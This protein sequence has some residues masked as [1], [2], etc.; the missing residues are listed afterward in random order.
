MDEFIIEGGQRL[1]GEVTLSGAK[2]SVLAIM[3][4]AI[5][6]EGATFLTNV[7]DLRDTRT[8]SAL[9]R[10][11]GAEVVYS[12]GRAEINSDRIDNLIAPYDLVSQ[13]RASF[14]V[15]GPM[16]ARY[17]EA[18]VSLPGGCAIGDRPITLH[19]DGLAAMGAEI[20][21]EHGYVKAKAPR[22]LQGADMVLDFPTVTGTENILMA[23]TLADG[24]TVIRNAAREPEIADLA[25]VLTAMGANIKGAGSDTIEVE[26]VKSLKGVSYEIM[27]DRIE[28][29]TFMIAAGITGGRITIKKAPISSLTAVEKKLKQTGCTI[30]HPSEDTMVIAGPPSIRPVDIKTEPYPGFPTDLQAQFMTLMSLANG[31]SVIKETIFEDRFIHVSELERL[32]AD[33]RMSGNTAIIEGVEKLS[34]APVMA[35]DLRASACLI[36][37]GMAA[38]GQTELSRIYHIDRG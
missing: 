14:L 12:D 38:E 13:M 1:E 21:L 3:A 26:G 15:L 28:A 17:G 24:L 31:L 25:R 8:I 6:A 20:I 32:G 5:L 35:T 22:G 4:A 11:L 27:A 33:I 19:L 37:A 36:L 29:G 18:E 16:L 2:N 30:D 34:G 10:H 23:A 7:P 9:L